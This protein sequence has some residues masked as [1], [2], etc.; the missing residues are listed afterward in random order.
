[1]KKLTLSA[2]NNS[3]YKLISCAL[4]ATLGVLSIIPVKTACGQSDQ[5]P[6]AIIAYYMGDGNNIDNYKTDQLT[7][8]IY[9][10]LHLKENKLVVDN[11]TDSLAI[12]RLVSLK[13]ASPGLKVILS[14]GGWGGCENCS[15][16]FNSESGRYE[17]AQSVLQLLKSYQADGL[18]LDWEYPAIESVPGHQ[19]L[20]QDRENFTSLI[21]IVRQTLGSGYELSFAAGGFRQFLDQSVEWEKVMPEVNYVN[22]MT[23]DLVN[24]YSKRT[25]HLTS[26]FSTPEQSES[27]DYA[28][29][30]LDSIGVPMNKIVIGLAFYARLFSGVEPENNGLYQKGKFSGYVNFK[31]IDGTLG[32]KAGYQQFWDNKA[33]S[34]Y[35]YNKTSKTF[36]TFDNLRSVYEKTKY[37]RERNLGGIMF[38]ELSGDKESGGLLDMIYEV[39]KEN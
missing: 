18:D 20:P 15:K 12:T 23:Y 11:A 22:M 26:L 2:Q 7:H 38:W 33:K 37:A 9:S 39:S 4:I 13:K 8:I 16:V 24:G 27:T 21:K 34:P 31:D 6:L 25:G 29:R 36:A 3:K 32:A 1:M 5:K 35:S 28:V 19:F 30:F 14:L 10:F 17:F